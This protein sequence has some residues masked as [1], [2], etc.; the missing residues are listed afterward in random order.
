MTNIDELFKVV[1]GAIPI[2][3]WTDSC[4]ETILAGQQQAEA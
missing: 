3:Q 1:L 4:A 2:R